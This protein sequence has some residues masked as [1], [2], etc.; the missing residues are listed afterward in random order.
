[1][2]CK[3]RFS[4]AALSLSV[5]LSAVS[6][7]QAAD[8]TSATQ[9]SCKSTGLSPTD[10]ETA[11]GFGYSVAVHGQ[12]ALVGIPQ[13]STAFVEPPVPPPY[14]S[15]RVAVFTC[16][17]STQAWTRTG[18]IQ[19]PATE[20]NQDIALGWAVALQGDLAAIGARY[21]AYVYKRHGQD[22]NQIVKISP[23]ANSNEQIGFVLAFKDDV[24]ALGVVIP[25][26]SSTVPWTYYVDVYQIVT[27]GD[28]G[29]A[30]RIARLKPPAGDTGAFGQAL[31]FDGETLVVGD[32]PT[33]T[34]WVYKRHGFTFALE[35][36]ISGAQA[37]PSSE[38][39][40]AVALSKEAILVGAP[41][42]YPINGDF[43]SYTEG[44]V[45]AFRHSSG[46]DSPWIE[47]QHFTPTDS[48][49][50]SAYAAFGGTLA[51]NSNGIAAIATP[52]SYDDET[53]S[54]FGPTFF[55]TL[56]SGQFVLMPGSGGGGPSTYFGIT[57]E[58][59]ISGSFFY[60]YG[61][62]LSGAGITNLSTLATN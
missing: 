2:A 49:P 11:D 60:E 20:A 30:I 44:A 61:F 59:L 33:P 9:P 36:T 28:H 38:F 51:L 34:V 25:S 35:Q 56:Q 53:G 58:Y 13:F 37:T 41:G 57:D 29:A 14:V 52:Q 46:P 31:A 21:G 55:Y 17:A 54:Q 24:L 8:T 23:A 4:L 42:E 3:L 47:T 15:G 7:V 18:T 50:Q 10:Q 19:L 1:M 40:S 32:S 39:G 5:V 48:G 27:L 43:G 22:W 26:T 45:Y 6:T 12:T 16:E 62:S